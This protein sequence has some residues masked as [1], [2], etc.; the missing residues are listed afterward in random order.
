MNQIFIIVKHNR[1]GELSY[2]CQAEAAPLH[3][4]QYPGW[5]LTSRMRFQ[6]ELLAREF[7]GWH[8]DFFKKH[9]MENE[10]ISIQEMYE[11][12]PTSHD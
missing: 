10:T 1:Y 12:H 2:L 6:S 11:L 7:I 3:W 9:L 4:A 5:P 8:L